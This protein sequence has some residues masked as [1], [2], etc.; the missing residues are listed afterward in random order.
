M[1]V[2]FKDLGTR[3]DIVEF[4]QTVAYKRAI[5]KSKL[6][7]GRCLYFPS[8]K[9]F[10]LIDLVDVVAVGYLYYTKNGTRLEHTVSD[11]DILKTFNDNFSRYRNIGVFFGRREKLI[12]IRDDNNDVCC[13]IGVNADVL[14]SN[15]FYDIEQND[16]FI[17][18]HLVDGKS[19]LIA[20]SDYSHVLTTKKFR[21]S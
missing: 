13:L 10:Y 9:G 12:V 21:L 4:R 17:L 15:D 6:I 7:H 8:H 3:E 16:D 18:V 11:M 20:K 19:F 2:K 14:L 5:A 1:I